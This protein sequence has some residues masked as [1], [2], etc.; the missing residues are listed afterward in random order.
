MDAKSLSDTNQSLVQTENSGASDN[1]EDM[2]TQEDLLKGT[3]PIKDSLSI[4]SIEQSSV[5]QDS[6]NLLRD[7]NNNQSS[8]G[9]TE[10]FAETDA[11]HQMITKL[12]N[13]RSSIITR[14]H[15]DHSNIGKSVDQLKSALDKLK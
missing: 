5:V 8:I 12:R 7:I 4:K 15:N 11:I 9:S 6:Q 1:N 10:W 13:F 2:A 14:L 3:I